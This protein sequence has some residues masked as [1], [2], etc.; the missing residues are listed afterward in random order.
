MPDKAE[1]QPRS[2]RLLFQLSCYSLQDEPVWARNSLQSEEK[3]TGIAALH[4]GR[5]RKLSALVGKLFRGHISCNMSLFPKVQ[6]ASSGF[7]GYEEPLGKLNHNLR[8]QD[9]E[10]YLD[11][12]N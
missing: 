12:C 8:L 6:S 2:C 1:R 4:L 9:K 3:L 5:E 10:N 7:E 11:S